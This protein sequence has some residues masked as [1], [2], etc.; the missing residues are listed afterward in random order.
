M[1]ENYLAK[2]LNN[3]LSDAE[4]AEFKN[5][6]EYA[7]YHKIMEAAGSARAPQFDV[8]R[9][10]E[11]LQARKTG[12]TPGVVQLKPW[13]RV[14]R[15]AAV[16]LLLVGLSVIY[17]NTRDETIRTG[18]AQRTEVILPDAS[19]VVLNSGTEIQYDEKNWDN[20]RLISLSGEAFFKVAK[21]RKFTVET[22]SGEVNVLGTQFNV[23]QRNGYFEVICFEGLVSVS[24][25][26]ETRKLPAGASFLTIDGNIIPAEGPDS[27][28]PGWINNESNF[29]STPLFYVLQEFERQYDMEVTTE[30]IDLNQLYTGSFSNT[31]MNLAL[32]S[33]ST[34]SQISFKLEGNKV[35]F[36]AGDTP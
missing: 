6:P 35:L 30:N 18:Y 15:V 23:E 8:E 28:I 20:E 4:F 5:T 27:D 9:A 2:W 21:G 7:A 17:L 31:N 29:Q 33:I 3:E 19:V 12:Q 13:K 24:F 1:K 26:G 34:P 14:L 10:F 16:L 11:D 32:Q 25:K 36:Y 22:E